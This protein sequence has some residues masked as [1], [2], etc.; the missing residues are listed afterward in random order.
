MDP[1]GFSCDYPFQQMLLVRLTGNVVRL[2][3]PSIFATSLLK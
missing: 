1:P 2:R 3:D